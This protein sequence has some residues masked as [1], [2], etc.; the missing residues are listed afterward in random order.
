[1]LCRVY[2]FLI[3]A[4]FTGTQL[5]C[6]LELPLLNCTLLQKGCYIYFL[7]YSVSVQV[8]IENERLISLKGIDMTELI[9]IEAF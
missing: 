4:D 6:K 8:P 2:V 5:A 3:K 1:M 7:I 9:I